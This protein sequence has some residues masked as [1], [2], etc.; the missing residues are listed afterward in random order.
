MILSISTSAGF[1]DRVKA[2][3]EWMCMRVSLSI[4]VYAAF[5]IPK[6]KKSKLVNGKGSK[7]KKSNVECA[8]QTGHLNQTCLPFRCAA[9]GECENIILLEG[10][11]LVSLFFFAKQ[12]KRFLN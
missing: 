1:S 9:K 10:Y 2:C 6:K 4:C 8:D 7:T 12:E 5:P 3:V 11:H